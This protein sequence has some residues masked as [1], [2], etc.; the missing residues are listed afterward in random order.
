MILCEKLD[1]LNYKFGLVLEN[2][3]IIASIHFFL[4]SNYKY[5]VFNKTY[6]LYLDK[7]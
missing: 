7:N 3:T 4:Y 2:K 6:V 1:F 5:F